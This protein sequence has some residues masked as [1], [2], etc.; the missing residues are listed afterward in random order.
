[1]RRAS[2]RNER[3]RQGAALVEALMSL[4]MLVLM[5]GLIT[6]LHRAY[7]ASLRTRQEARADAWRRA[8]GGCVENSADAVSL[9]DALRSGDLPIL[10]SFAA[11]Q[12]ATGRAQRS[13]SGA[14]GQH[15]SIAREVSLPCNIR[16]SEVGNAEAGQWVFDLFN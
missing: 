1:M 15:V 9:V 11:G 14:G 3:R 2:H 13:V 6:F 4:A 16:P 7:A 8:L 10:D 5:C 12:D